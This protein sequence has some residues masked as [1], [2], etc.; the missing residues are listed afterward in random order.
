MTIYAILAM[1]RTLILLLT[2]THTLK[3][4]CGFIYQV[5]NH[6]DKNMTCDGD[7]SLIHCGASDQ[8]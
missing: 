6:R 4:G 7:R 1:E 3:R 5:P 8:R 2:H